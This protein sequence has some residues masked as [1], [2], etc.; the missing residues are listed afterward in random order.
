MAWLYDKW[1]QQGRHANDVEYHLQAAS[2]AFYANR[3]SLCKRHVSIVVRLRFFVLTVTSVACLV[4]GHRLPRREDIDKMDVAFRSFARQIVGP[5]R[6][7]NWAQ[8]RHIVI[9]S[10]NARVALHTERVGIRSW[11]YESLRSYCNLAGWVARLPS[12]R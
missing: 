6:D 3:P 7:M 9:H 5:P 10:W 2:K 12:S 8:P 11:G 4:Q 1:S